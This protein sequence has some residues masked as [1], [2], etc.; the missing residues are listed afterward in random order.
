MSLVLVKHRL[1]PVWDGQR[2]KWDKFKP[3]PKTFICPPPPPTRCD[4]GSGNAPLLASGS[5]EPKPGEMTESTKRVMG[6]FGRWLERP[7]LVP[8]WPLRDLFA[9]RCPDCKTDGVWDM[10]TDEWW[11]LGPEDY[12]TQGSERPIEREW[13]GG[14]FDLLDES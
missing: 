3:S 6:R 2:V 9:F 14:L 8:A 5:R 10:R 1:P 13:S 11:T 4:C 12:G 7:T